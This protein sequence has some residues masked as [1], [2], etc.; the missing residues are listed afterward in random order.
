MKKYLMTLVILIIS[1]PVIALADMNTTTN[2][3]NNRQNTAVSTD[4]NASSQPSD[5]TITTNVKSAFLK[6]KLF[7]NAD[8]SAFSIK[9]ETH[10]G[11]VHLTGTADN[12]AQADNASSLAKKVDGVKNVVSDVQ[13]K[14]NK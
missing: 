13:V 8:I 11:T 10:D 9:V 14:N 1:L 4:G 6:Q 3:E 12:Q 5:T 7:G 2:S